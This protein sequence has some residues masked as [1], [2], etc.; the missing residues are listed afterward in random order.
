SRPALLGGLPLRK[1]PFPSWPRFASPEE[2]AM[3]R[4]LKS[5]KWFR[6]NGQEVAAFEKAYAEMTGARFCL[7]T[8]NGTSALLTC[9]HALDIQPGDEVILPP[10][11][12]VA[13]LNVVLLNYALPIF[14]DTDPATFQI[15]SKKVEEATTPR[16][17][18]LMPVHIG[19]SAADL[20]TL[21]E[22]S[23]KRRIPLLEDACQAHLGE[24]RGRKVGTLGHL[25]CFSFQ[26]SKNL[27]SGEGGAILTDREDLVEK[28][29]TFHNNSRP[30]KS[31]G[32]ES[33]YVG[34]GAN[35]RLTEFQ[36]ALLVAQMQRLEEQ[37][38]VRQRNA[39][40]LTK[41]LDEVG[42]VAPARMYPGC[43]GNAYHLFMARY[44]KEEFSGLSRG[45]F[46]K[47]L[48]AEGIPC[49]A[50][51]APLNK[52]PYIRDTLSSRGYRAI[53]PA[54]LLNRWEERTAC[55]VNDKLCQ[56]A[57]WL[58]QTMLLGTSADMEQIAAAVQKIRRHAGELKK[59]EKVTD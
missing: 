50:G 19:G 41:L 31:T 15:D 12:F 49:S 51:Y 10:Y 8:A 52:E 17:K 43:T 57:F 9:L 54:E 26:A 21:L 25:G 53:Y 30:R 48:Q 16:T 13:T 24:W 11:T 38:R 36:G 29:Y 33:R 34:R 2:E 42:G 23:K 6:G 28:C 18:L 47:A 1:E 5:G 22:I 37:T 4:T 46:L 35:L 55:P 7:A 40:I 45:T 14:V 27:N 20:D 56:E 39:A 44:R 58:A 32:F 59:T 3:L